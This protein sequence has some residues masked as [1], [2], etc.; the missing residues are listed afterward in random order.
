M[1]GACDS[2]FPY[3]PE[4]K[5]FRMN[6]MLLNNMLKYRCRAKEIMALLDASLLLPRP[7]LGEGVQSAAPDRA[8]MSFTEIRL[9][10]KTVL[11]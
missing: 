11:P 5:P 8:G 4:K 2:V 1:R 6:L 3:W 10:L 7:V 9:S